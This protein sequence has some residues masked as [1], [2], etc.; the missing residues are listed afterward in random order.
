MFFIEMLHFSAYSGI[1]CVELVSK[2]DDKLH[3]N[4]FYQLVNKFDDKLHVNIFYHGFQIW[5]DQC[6]IFRD[7]DPPPP[8]QSITLTQIYPLAARFE[9]VLVWGASYIIYLPCTEIKVC[10]YSQKYS[11]MTDFPLL[12]KIKHLMS[13]AILSQQICWLPIRCAYFI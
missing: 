11:I 12:G 4:I 2:F 10:F 8:P 3:V 6:I 1:I 7:Q 9:H 5:G 13:F